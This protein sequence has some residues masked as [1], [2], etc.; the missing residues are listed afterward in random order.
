V[1]HL[2]HSS[3]HSRLA[4]L[5]SAMTSRR[6]SSR[7]GSP[8]LDVVCPDRAHNLRPSSLNFFKASAL[9][10]ASSTGLWVCAVTRYFFHSVALD[11]VL[12]QAGI[13]VTDT[14]A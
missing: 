5:I 9:P 8:C 1:N 13:K 11:S 6:A 10:L 4:R 3:P 2:Q 12:D 14:L 7:V